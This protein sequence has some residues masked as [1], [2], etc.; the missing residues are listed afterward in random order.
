[1]TFFSLI[2]ACTL[3]GGI[4]LNN[5]I[6]WNIPED[7]ELFK[8]I[9][10]D[11]NCYIKKNAVIMGKNTWNS[12]P[13]KPL[14]NR[15]NIIITSKPNEIK[16]DDKSIVVCKNFDD[17]IDYCE[18]SV[19]INKIFV[20]G[21]KSLYDLCIDNE[22]YF[23]MIENV[24]LSI[25]KDNYICDTYINLKKIINKFKKY[26][27]NDIIFNSNFIYIKYLNLK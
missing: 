22:Y 24:H 10:T 19:L 13:Y 8:K 1:M 15:I 18:K 20:I 6:P 16:A 26:D 3:E 25:V 27:I 5:K 4:G 2:L 17:A 11:V 9:T 14:K 7:M 21:G 23:N 12:L